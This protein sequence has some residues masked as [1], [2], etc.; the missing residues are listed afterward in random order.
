M[1][2]AFPA[3]FVTGGIPFLA[4][5]FLCLVNRTPFLAERFPRLAYRFSFLANRFPFLAK[6][7]PSLAS[8]SH[9]LVIGFP[10]MRS[11]VS[12]STFRSAAWRFFPTPAFRMSSSSVNAR[13]VALAVLMSLFFVC[14]FSA[15]AQDGAWYKGNT[16][17]HTVLSGHGDGAPEHVARWYLDRGYHFLIL[18]EHNRFIRPD[19]VQLPRN[20]RSDFILIPGE[21]VTGRQ[22]IHTTAM[23]VRGLVDWTADHE[24]KHQIVQSHVDSTILAGGTP[25]LN[26]PNFNWAVAFDDVRPVRRLHLFELYNGHPAV[27]N[28]GDSTHISTERLWDELLTD[29]MLIYGVSSDDAHQFHTWGT[30]VSNPGRGWVMVQADTLTP[31]AITRAMRG[32]RFYATSGIIL[33]DVKRDRRFAVRVDEEAT[34]REM[35]S[36]YLTG[37]HVDQGPPGFEIQFVGP[38]GEILQ[39]VRHSVAEFPVPEGPAYVRAKI[40]FRRLRSGGG[41]EAF[42]AWTQPFFMDDRAEIARAYEESAYEID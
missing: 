26:H 27:Y 2:A 29:G 5:R 13:R 4:E 15:A 10:V 19:S 1:S 24:H 9:T 40:I 32:G 30:D 22:I 8:S 36:P 17:A 11:D 39:R 33:E 42:Y 35:G 41:Y 7:V 12:S 25:I 34:R 31:A 23:N 21:E 37:H 3:H 20:R 28:F 38:R 6:R 14:G 18:S 16:H